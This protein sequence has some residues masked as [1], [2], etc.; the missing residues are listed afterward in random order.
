VLWDV[1]GPIGGMGGGTMP[2]IAPKPGDLLTLSIYY[3][4]KGRDFFTA[5]DLTQKVS[6]TLS[7]PPAPHVIYTAAEVAGLLTVKAS[8]PKADVRLWEFTDCH[9]TTY[10]GVHGTMNGPWT[11]SQIIDTTTGGS[12]GRVVMSPSPLWNYGQN[13]GAWLRKTE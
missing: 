6:Q 2:N 9:A 13:F 8:A 7:L 11:T 3:N 10:T 4:Q 1:V 12:G 5:S